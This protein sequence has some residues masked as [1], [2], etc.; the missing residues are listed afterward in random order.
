MDFTKLIPGIFILI[1]IMLLW[2]AY[3]VGVKKKTGLISGLDARTLNRV[4]KVDKLVKDCS[5]G[6][7]LMACACFIAVIFLLYLGIV[8]K[9][10]G[11]A[12]I[13]ISSINLSRITLDMDNKLKKKIY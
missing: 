13:I 8:G 1:G 2:R 4:K 6:L 5:N 12:I 7:V 3:L 10:L 9:I 11:L